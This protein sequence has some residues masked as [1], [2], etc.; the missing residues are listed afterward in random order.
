MKN[1]LWTGAGWPKTK[2]NINCWKIAFPD[3]TEQK[4]GGSREE[5]L[6][7][8]LSNHGKVIKILV[9]FMDACNIFAN[10]KPFNLI[11]RKEVLL[12]EVKKLSFNQNGFSK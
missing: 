3:F 7:C 9:I 1:R 10:D 2:A 11:T 12:I 8:T 4:G 5:D 6:N